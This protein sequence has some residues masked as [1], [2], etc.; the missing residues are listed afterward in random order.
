MKVVY[1]RGLKLAKDI[2]I[3][4]EKV[5]DKVITKAREVKTMI[6]NL[7]DKMN[8]PPFNLRNI[9]HYLRILFITK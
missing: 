3:K 5:G 7:K 8:Q 9:L 6:T 2:A 1:A 4:I